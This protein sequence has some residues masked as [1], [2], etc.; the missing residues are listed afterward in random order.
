MA[1]SVATEGALTVVGALAGGPLA[2]LL[3]VLAKSLAAERQKSRVEAALR[4]IEQV[5]TEHESALNA[6]S[7]AQYKLINES[8]LAILHT[9]AEEK[10]VYLRRAVRNALAMAALDSQDAVVLGRA[11]RDIS[12]H[13]AR[14]LCESFAYDRV[15]VTS[16]DAAHEMKVL[17]IRPGTPEAL[18]VTGLVSLGLLE[19]AEPTWDESGLLRYSSVTAKLIA[20]IR[21]AP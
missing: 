17:T 4:D 18:I 8:I 6:L 3:P 16:I 1:G 15:Q 9:T 21:R 10:L 2:A 13:E 20:L 14:F 11:V 12:A 19:A 7:D 5:L